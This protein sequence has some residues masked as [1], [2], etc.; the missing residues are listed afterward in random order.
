[1]VPQITTRSGFVSGIFLS[2]REMLQYVIVNA[3]KLTGIRPPDSA[4]T[5][6]FEVSQP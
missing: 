5:H 3:S 1:M 4:L 2:C 6:S